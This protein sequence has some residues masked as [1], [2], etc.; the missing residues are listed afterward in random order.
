MSEMHGA[1]NGKAKEE[2]DMSNGD[3]GDGFRRKPGGIYDGQ[4]CSIAETSRS[5]QGSDCNG[6]VFSRSIKK[7]EK[8]EIPCFRWTKNGS[9]SDSFHQLMNSD[10]TSISRRSSNIG[11]Y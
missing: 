6:D 9:I 4:H 11:K 7:D 1:P 10:V 3:L 2:D 8:N 5:R